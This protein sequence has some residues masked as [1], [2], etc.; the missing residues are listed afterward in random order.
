MIHSTLP[1]LPD[2]IVLCS[3]FLGSIN[4]NAVHNSIDVS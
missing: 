4:C 3:Q 2:N 1:C